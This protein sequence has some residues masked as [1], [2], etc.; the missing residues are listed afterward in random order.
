MSFSTEV[1]HFNT[2]YNLNAIADYNKF[3]EQNSS[4]V[5]DDTAPSEFEKTLEAASKHYPVHDKNDPE[6]LGNFATKMGNAFYDGL[7]SVNSMKL[8]AERMQEDIAMGG[9]TSIHDAMI[10]AEKASLSMQMAIQVRNRLISAYTDI[11]GMAI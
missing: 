7:N 10:A 6:G 11:T 8:E 5:F 4:F 2:T 9:A 1:S 3:L